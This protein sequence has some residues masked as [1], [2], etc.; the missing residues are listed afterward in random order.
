MYI[1]ESVTADKPI[2]P[3]GSPFARCALKKVLPGEESGDSYNTQNSRTAFSI[4]LRPDVHDALRKKDA[5][6]NSP[7]D[8]N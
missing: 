2:V 6:V 7:Y 8:G 1:A 4:D 3:T 5:S